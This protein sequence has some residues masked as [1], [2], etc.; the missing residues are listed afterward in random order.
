M[1][2]GMLS[3]NEN[4][5]LIQGGSQAVQLP[6]VD[7]IQALKQQLSEKTNKIL[8]LL[9]KLSVANETIR[10]LETERAEQ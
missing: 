8:E 5:Q 6:E 3:G 1:K 2:A 4:A 10:A 9:E 7:E